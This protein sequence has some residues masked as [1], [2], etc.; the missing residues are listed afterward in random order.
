[1]LDLF[2]SYPLLTF[3]LLV[4][5]PVIYIQTLVFLE[6]RTIRRLGAF[7]P[8]VKPYL[9]FSIDIVFRSISN[10]WRHKDLEFWSWLFAS[11]PHENSP[12]VEV[13]LAMQR[14]IFTADPEN[15]KAILAT[16]FQD[17]GKGEPFHKDWNDF[18]GD[19][20]FTTDGEQWHNSRQLIRP[21]FVKNRVQDLDIFEKH[22]QHLLSKISGTGEEV[23]ISALFYRFT[24]DSAT[25]YLLGKSVN[26][27]GNSDSGF[28]SAFT[29][30]QTIQ[31]NIARSGPFN[32]LLPRRAFHAALKVINEFVEPFIES[33][34]RM[35]IADLKERTNQ[36]FLHALAATGTRDRKVIRDQVVA[37]LLAG[38][39]TTAGALSFTF[40]E[41]SNHPEIVEKL[42]QE[43]LERVGRTEPPTY[44]DLKNM[45]YLQHSMNETLRLY[46]SVPFN[47]RLALHNTTLPT[48]GGPNGTDPIGILKDTPIA[49]SAIHLHRRADLYPPPSPSF[50][51]VLTYSPERWESWTPKP[52]QYIPFNGG[53]RIC[54]GQQFALTEMAYTIV[55]ILQRFERVDKHWREEDLGMKS[56][57][58]MCPA[59]GV[60]VG[61][62]DAKS[63]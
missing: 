26:S 52:W 34:L 42:R 43:I 5:L 12:T 27:L 60:K 31:N 41:L 3:S 2:Y 14:F 37:V 54:I 1:M 7:A 9:P 56:E 53:P 33:V 8:V 36:S 57:I 20:I 61:F 28:A 10:S 29:E 30:V 13:V 17:Y 51:P 23:N 47:V 35:N 22:V 62:W 55:R 59:N 40:Q 21:Q 6:N 11:S 63:G 19:S 24:L 4:F 18:L 58:V 50:A 46:P 39:D 45:P 25:D 48:G 44:E 38:R 32:K 15:I 49:Y 16:Q